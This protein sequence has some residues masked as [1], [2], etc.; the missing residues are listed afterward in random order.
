[1]AVNYGLLKESEIEIMTEFRVFYDYIIEI[2][3]TLYDYLINSQNQNISEE[4]FENLIEMSKKSEILYNDLLSNCIWLIQKNEPRASHLRFIIAIVYS[5]KS[6]LH[7]CDGI[8][9]I[10]KFFFKKKIMPELFQEFMHAYQDTID[11]SKKIASSLVE[12][13]ISAVVQ[14]LKEGFEEYHQEIKNLVRKCAYIHDDNLYRDNKDLI[15]FIINIGRLERIIDRQ[16]NILA[17]F[18]YIR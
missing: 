1:M 13:D 10:A 4:E 14:N 16:E 7:I 17:D 11:L 9:K 3:V 6:L 12:R 5:I 18:A 15:N 8:M 2:K